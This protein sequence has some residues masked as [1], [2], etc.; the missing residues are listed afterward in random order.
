M[1]DILDDVSALRDKLLAQKDQIIS[2]RMDAKYKNYLLGITDPVFG[3]LDAVI[4]MDYG[5]NLVGA[6]RNVIAG[7]SNALCVLK[8]Q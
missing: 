5:G 2:S 8:I 7:G 3:G 4:T 1:T 6:L